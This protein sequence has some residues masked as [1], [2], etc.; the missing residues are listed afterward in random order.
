MDLLTK[1]ENEKIEILN[2]SIINGWQDVYELKKQNK[3][4]AT[5]FDDRANNLA[6]AKE[7]ALNLLQNNKNDEY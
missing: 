2:Q 7:I 1:N 5:T 6:Q 3:Q 4:I